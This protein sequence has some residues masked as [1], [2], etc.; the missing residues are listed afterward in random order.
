[1]N[2]SETLEEIQNRE[3]PWDIVIIGGGATGA[4]CALDA[5]AR[6]FDVL[7]L[8][9]SDFGKGTSSRSTKLVHGGVRYLAKGDFS[10]VRESL[11]ERGILLKNAPH[12]VK[13][14]GFVVPCYGFWEK[15]Y[16]AAG[17]KIYGFLSGSYG[18]GKSHILSKKKTVEELSNIKQGNLNGGVLY[19]DGQFDDARLLIDILKT[20]HQKKA[21]LLNYARVF[22]FTKNQDHKIEAVN[23]QD[24]E[25]G[26]IFSVQTRAVI[27]ATG[28]YCDWVRRY[29][30]RR[31]PDLIAPS[32]GIH[33]V[34]DRSFLP[35]KYAVM[36]PNTSDGRVLFAIPW[37]G[38]TL[39]GT[40]ETKL[41]KPQIEPV[42][43]EDEIEFILQTVKDYLAKP[44]KRKDIKS[45]F[46]GIRP[47]VES[48]EK[49]N[50]AAL[51]RDYTIEIDDFNL[52]TITG[53]KWT[54]YRKMAEDAVNQSIKLAN[55]P[56]RKCVTQNLKIVNFTNDLHKED[57]QFAEK[58]HKNFEYTVGDVAYAVRFEMARTVED[59]LARRL[60]ILFLDAMAAIE[61]APKIAEIMAIEFG[62]DKTWVDEQISVFNKVAENY[63]I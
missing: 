30:T 39:V 24:A 57:P 1:M 37:H 51:S 42:A 22:S 15:I 59:I 27:N 53:G 25:S 36:I 50:T 43:F 3:K 54:T 20:A 62:K 38:K 16:Y 26:G 41:E 45:V 52:L 56:E 17:L 19:F 40:T 44:P 7:L 34:F 5:A 9:Q 47:L 21:R 61:I 2:R 46:A 55:L 10:L 48:G 23:Y 60:R 31:A 58:L 6:G 35:G 18:F 12:L 28:A 13:K 33:L 8:E 4:G 32:Q 11:K 14:L 49:K 29:S 63:V